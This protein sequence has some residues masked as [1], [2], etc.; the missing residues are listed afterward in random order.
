MMMEELAAQLKALTGKKYKWRKRKINCL[1]HVINLTTQALIAMYSKSLHFDP[2]NPKAHIPTSWDEVGLIRAIVVKERSS[3][4]HKQIWHMVQVKNKLKPLQLILDMKVCWSS[5]YLMLDRAERK[6]E[7]VN[8]FIDELYW[9]EKDQAKRYKIHNLK[10][11]DDEWARHAN[12]AQQAFSSEQVSTLHLAIPTLEALYRAWSTRA[13][14]PKYKCFVSSL[15]AACTKIDKYYKKTTESPAYIMAMILN[16][17]EK[18]KYFKKHWSPELQDN[19]VECV[20]E[21]FKEQYL[22]LS[23]GSSTTQ[24]MQPKV[25]RKLNILLRELSDDEEILTTEVGAGV[26]EDPKWPWLTDFHKYLD[27]V[28]QVPDG[29]S[30]IASFAW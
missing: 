16:P 1:A 11:M 2:K 18:M 5:T 10:L 26:P 6:K 21:V 15:Q 7:C 24:F 9:D 28:E 14:R 19:V 4:K 20:E 12:N 30:A 13:D 23:G 22:S 29:C 3:S 8:D 27:V 17:K 25:N